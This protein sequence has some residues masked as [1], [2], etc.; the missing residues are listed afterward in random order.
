VQGVQS[1]SCATAQTQGLVHETVDSGESVK[2]SFR[3][4]PSAFPS[5]QKPESNFINMLVQKMPESLSTR[6]RAHPWLIGI[7]S[8]ILV[9]IMIFDWSW[10]RRPLESYVTKKTQRTFT[11]SDLDVKLGLNPTIVLEDLV[12]G[13]SEWGRPEPMITAK[14]LEFSLP[15]H[16]LLERQILISRVTLTDARILMERLNDDRRNWVLSE[17]S[18]ASRSRFRIGALSINNGHLEYFDYGLPFAVT[19]AASTFDPAAPDE[20][21]ADAKPRNL[22]YSAR[23]KFAGKY[24][25]ATFSGNA[26]TGEVLSFQE[27]GIPFP[28]KAN[29]VAGTTKIDV[30]GT[31]ADVRNISGIDVDLHIAGQTMANLYPFLLLPL[32]ASPPYDLRGHLVLKGNEF[33]LEKL[34]GQIGSTDVQGQAA[35]VRREPRPLLTADLHSNL[36][37]LADLGPLVGVKTKESMGK[38]KTTQAETS[39]RAKAAAAERSR[40]VERILP[41]GSFEGSRLQAIDAEVTLETRKLK[42]STDLP[43]ENLR[44]VLKLHDAILKLEPLELGFAG[45][46]IISQVTLDAR[47]PIIK[48]SLQTD[49]R[50]LK[51]ARLVPENPRLAKAGGTI[52]GKI[53]LRGSGNSIADMAAQSNGSLGAAI[54]GGRI[55]NLLDALSG[56]N[57]GEALLVLARGDQDIAV[58]CG[59]A[60]FDVKAGKGTS[61]VFEVDTEQTQITGVGHFDFDQER[62]DLRIEPKPKKPGIL[63]FRTPIRIQGSFRD[64]ELTLEKAPLAL[65][66]VAVLALGLINP[67]AALIPLIETGSGVDSDCADVVMR[68][69]DRA[70]ANARQ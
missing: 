55:S 44:A 7:V 20:E 11:I 47:Q 43:F 16:E 58:R 9:L 41:A 45:G 25:D 32:P 46:S 6:F 52:G 61:S 70:P 63:S 64:P 68:V 35:Y 17:P 51:L 65:R 8:A 39:T 67:L 66:G 53:D 12:F 1:P 27:S 15:L 34:R 40:N 57:G 29:L 22:R 3:R 54:A 50:R 24:R 37:N 2:S 69:S 38:P 28:L 49:L 18:D 59:G 33:T 48:A 19:V 10:L 23:F 30:E 36:T 5:G 4:T 62:L 26:L 21:D 13:N 31:V 60:A 14:R 42:A 56:L